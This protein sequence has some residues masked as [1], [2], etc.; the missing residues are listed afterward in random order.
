MLWYWEWALSFLCNLPA[1]RQGRQGR[2]PDLLDQHI[3]VE[4]IVDRAN[5]FMD[6]KL[7][8]FEVATVI[9][10]CT[11]ERKICNAMLSRKDGDASEMK[12]IGNKDKTF[13]F[14]EIFDRGVRVESVVIL[15]DVFGGNVVFLRQV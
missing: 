7:G 11:V 9:V 8:L 6:E 15:D 13:I 2:N 12:V 5:H 1:G 14:G 10:V 4:E 3:D